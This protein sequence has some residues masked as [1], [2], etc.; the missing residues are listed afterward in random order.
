MLIR[1]SD[2]L[3]PLYFSKEDLMLVLKGHDIIRRYPPYSLTW[4][5]NVIT[6]KKNGKQIWRGY[7]RDALSVIYS[8]RIIP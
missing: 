1:F 8:K 6:I 4:G 3:T 7:Y 2:S 5:G